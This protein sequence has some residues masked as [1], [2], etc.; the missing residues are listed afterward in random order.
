MPFIVVGGERVMVG[1]I[2]DWS[3]SPMT[4]FGQV[5]HFWVQGQRQLWTPNMTPPFLRSLGPQ[6]ST[7]RVMP[8]HR[9][10][11]RGDVEES[12][13][14]CLLFYIL[15][16][17]MVFFS[18]LEVWRCYNGLSTP[19]R[20]RELRPIISLRDLTDKLKLVCCTGLLIRRVCHSQVPFLWFDFCLTDN[21][22][23][24]K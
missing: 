9:A 11:F 23:S 13:R 10:P 20:D 18:I 2:L 21:S 5:E 6:P 8:P 17:L 4:S 15:I 24:D 7:G 14:A 12:F 19:G 3:E 16:S 1:A 22:D